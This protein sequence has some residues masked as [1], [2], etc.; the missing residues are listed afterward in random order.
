MTH[1]EVVALSDDDLRIK[2]EELRGRMLYEQTNEALE[3]FP[4]SDI[5]AMMCIISGKFMGVEIDG[6][7]EAVPN[8]PNDI[9]AAWE[10]VE[11]TKTHRDIHP[12]L[13]YWFCRHMCELCGW[14]VEYL[15]EDL[16]P[17]A[18]AH[19]YVLAMTQEE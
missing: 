11:W 10:L 18:I 15:L 17:R 8:Y 5:G 6:H 1:D 9:A 19:A 14:E 4:P 16:T 12:E 2:V 13:W 3:F 7:M